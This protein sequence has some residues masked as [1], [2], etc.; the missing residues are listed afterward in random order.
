MNE[1]DTGPRKTLVM[2]SILKLALELNSESHCTCYFNRC[3]LKLLYVHTHAVH[4]HEDIA[5]AKAKE[6]FGRTTLNQ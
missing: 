5:L 2:I 6:F 3:I 4:V 1:C